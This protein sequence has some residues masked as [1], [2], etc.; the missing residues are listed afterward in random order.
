MAANKSAQQVTSAA[1]SED[2]F[3]QCSLADV[4][5]ELGVSRQRAMVIER[6]ALKK[7]RA[8]LEAKGIHSSTDFAA[9]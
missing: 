6:S 4:A 8:A 9:D 1:W 2:S 7:V 3:Y 5:A